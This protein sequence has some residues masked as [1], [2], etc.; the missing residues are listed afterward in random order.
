MYDKLK[1][2]FEN[3]NIII[4]GYGR[5]GRSTLNLIKDMNVKS[6]TVA[7]M[8]EVTDILP[9]G[10]ETVTGERYLSCLSSPDVDIIMKAPGVILLD[11]VSKKVKAK[12]TSQ[13]DLF[14]R[15][16]PSTVIGVTGTKGKSTTSSLIYHILK[17]SGM[18]TMLIGNI[19]VPPLDRIDDFKTQTRV[20]CE[21]SCHQLEY[22]SASPDIAVLL[23]IYP[24]HLD[25]YKDFEDYANAKLNIFKYQ[26]ESDTL[27][28][29]DELSTR[30]D[31]KAEITLAGFGG[32]GDIGT[33]DGGIYLF[34][35][36]TPADSFTT[37]LKGEHNLYNTAIA[38]A[39]AMMV[40]C[41]LQQCI[42]ALA[43]FKGLEHRLEYVGTFDGV[44]YINDS[45]STAPETA[46]AALKAYPDT[47]TLIVGGMDRGIPYD[48]LA[49]FLNNNASLK[50]LIIMPD[51]GKRIAEKIT[52]SAIE[53]IFVQDLSEAV[54]AARKV[55]E[56]R[57]ILS[58][59]SASYG[60]F[61]NF[62]ERGRRFKELIIGN[63]SN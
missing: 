10:V 36:F 43:T 46:V 23:N 1:N 14:L 8:N 39:A 19:G 6:I 33:R 13:T 37:L 60:F 41:T 58:P 34:D 25:H 61:K 11:K 16:C 5:E 26:N 55:S 54:E 22:V 35:A 48:V 53:K 49:N 63:S 27:I 9:E 62:E 32:K 20:I 56:K 7:D 50:H 24:E 3:K 2:F 29:A 51:S 31:T 44:E 57:C 30:A 28:I 47:D 4:L 15:F 18:D 21:M 38:F 59:A 12:I 52:N 17:E 45:I 40:D 42:D